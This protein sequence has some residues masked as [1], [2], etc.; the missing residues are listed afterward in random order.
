MKGLVCVVMLTLL[1]SRYE[2]DDVMYFVAICI[3]LRKLFAQPPG[4]LVQR[5]YRCWN[6][7]RKL[8]L[9]IRT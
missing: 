2:R 1:L 8:F 9:V 6:L 4:H 3:I 5:F 7:I